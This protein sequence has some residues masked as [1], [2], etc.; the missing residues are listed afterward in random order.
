MSNTRVHI[1]LI[2]DNAMDAQLIRDLLADA[3]KSQRNTIHF[4]LTHAHQ[5]VEGI[6]QIH[7]KIFDIIFYK[8]Y[9]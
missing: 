4:Q 3:M 5:L 1:L 9:H 2:E 8:L 7:Q 6:E